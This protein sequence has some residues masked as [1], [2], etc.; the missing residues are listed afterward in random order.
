MKYK[1]PYFEELR[2]DDGLF[3]F[4]YKITNLINNKFYSITTNEP[5]ILEFNQ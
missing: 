3:H 4:V 5:Y 2:G 1:I